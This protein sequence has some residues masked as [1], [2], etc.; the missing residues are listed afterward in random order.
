MIGKT[1]KHYKIM[2]K[3]G[4]GGMGVVYRAEDTK[5]NRQVALKFLPA[6]YTG[7]AQAKQRF[8]QEA[9]TASTL[10]HPHIC[11]IH[12]I[13][14][15]DDGNLFIV[16]ACYE[17]KSLK[18]LIEECSL[19]IE[20]V[21]DVAIQIAEGLAGAHEKQ[22]VHRDIKPANILLTKDDQAKI[23]DFGLAKLAGQVGLT[24]TGTTIGTIAYMS[25]EQTRGEDVDHRTDIWSYGVVLYEMFTGKLPFR[26]EYDQAVVYS[27]MNEQPE[28]I[29]CLRADMPIE[30]GQIVLKCLAKEKANRYETAMLSKEIENLIKPYIGKEVVGFRTEIARSRRGGV[31]RENSFRMY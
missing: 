2:E 11:T 28:P 22:I 23:L 15:A 30:L 6:E 16:M 13:N 29:H 4:E 17:G 8:L 12:E 1:I 25:P 24:K 9:Q 19:Y 21:L 26:G 7:D 5:L 14:E 31:A 3:L 10:D 20:R 27:I 18:D